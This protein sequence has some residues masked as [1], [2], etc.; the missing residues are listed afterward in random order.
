MEFMSLCAQSCPT[1]CEPLGCSP[2]GSSIHE[3]LQAKILEWVVRPS[4]RD[5]P[6]PGIEPV[7]PS[8]QADSL[9]AEPPKH[10]N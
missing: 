7:S 10:A 2:P 4:S 3:I 1:L 9:P 5:L 8:L 6:D